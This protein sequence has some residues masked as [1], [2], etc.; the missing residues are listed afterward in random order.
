MISFV[1]FAPVKLRF[2]EIVAPVTHLMDL[3]GFCRD[4]VHYFNQKI[5][6]IRDLLIMMLKKIAHIC[7]I[8]FVE[9]LLVQYGSQSVSLCLSLFFVSITGST[10]P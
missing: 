3:R 9:A 5:G 2:T 6:D 8:A 1:R 7:K 10:L 4:M